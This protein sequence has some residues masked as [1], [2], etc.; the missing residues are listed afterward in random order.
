M[1]WTQNSLGLLYNHLGDARTALAYHKEALRSSKERGARTVQGIAHLGIGQDLYELGRLDAACAAF[2]AAIAIKGELGQS[3]RAVEAKSGLARTLLALK[4][5]DAAAV[6]VDEVLDFLATDTLQGA[7][8]PFLVYL[9]C[10]RVLVANRDPRAASL[11]REA[12][13]LLQQQAD[14]IEERAWRDSFLQNIQANQALLQEYRALN[15]TPDSTH[16]PDDQTAH[17]YARHR[18]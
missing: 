18:R 17:K 8:Q 14:R 9:D 6:L 12:V 13:L 2:T 15:L 4:R 16:A 7:R 3:Q 11:L 1:A 10:Y 5:S